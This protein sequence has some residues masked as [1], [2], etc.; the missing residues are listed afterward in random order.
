M[1]NLLLTLFVVPLFCSMQLSAT[2]LEL[3]EVDP[4]KVFVDQ[5]LYIENEG[6]VIPV[7]N[8]ILS[9][10]KVLAVIQ[11]GETTLHSN[12]W[13]FIYPPD[14]LKYSST[15]PMSNVSLSTSD[16]SD[17]EECNC[18]C[19]KCQENKPFIRAR[20]ALNTC[21]Q[22]LLDKPGTTLSGC[23]CK[24]KPFK[25]RH[26]DFF[27]NEQSGDLLVSLEVDSQDL[28]VVYLNDGDVSEFL[29]QSLDEEDSVESVIGYDLNGAYYYNPN[30]F[31]QVSNPSNFNPHR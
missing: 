19:E 5:G 11:E 24:P 27:I 25:P 10:H 7:H 8:I 2:D 9:D 20:G 23:N 18:G 1:K 12:G 15:R 28:D 17:G 22:N 26:G 6:I 4:T 16:K 3:L 30:S 29:F 21:L 13:I 14:A 31:F